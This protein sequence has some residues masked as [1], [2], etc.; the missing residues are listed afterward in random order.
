MRRFFQKIDK[1]GFSL[2]EVMATVAILSLG[3]LV[4]HDGL[5]RSAD[6]LTHFNS[7]LAAQEWGEDKIWDLKEALLFSSETEPAENSG[8]FEVSG[9]DFQWS[10][11][12][13]AL[14]GTD[15]AFIVNLDIAW[16]EGNK[17]VSLKRSA[18]VSA[19]RQEESLA[20]P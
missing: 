6:V 1:R 13:Q 15:G 12:N 8:N 19:S 4:I 10:A 20:T 2:I 9:R 11:G 18:Y 3:T 14:P 17:P 5:L 16:Q 7:L